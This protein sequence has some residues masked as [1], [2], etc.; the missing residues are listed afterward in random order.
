M[1]TEPMR[2][3]L[4]AIART[5]EPSDYSEYSGARNLWFL[6]RDRVLSALIRRAL[7]EPTPDGFALTESG[8]AALSAIKGE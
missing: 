7:I 8:N 4:R 5:G 1:L 3:E 2:R 6:A